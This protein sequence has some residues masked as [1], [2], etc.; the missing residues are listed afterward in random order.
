MTRK[1]TGLFG[2]LALFVLAVP[3]VAQTP[4]GGGPATGGGG[5]RPIPPADP[6]T[7]INRDWN[8][9]SVLGRRG[10]KLTGMVAVAGGSLP[11][12]PVLVTV[13]CD[14]KA[15][16]TTNTDP[17]GFF[18]I[19]AIDP[20]GSTTINANPKPVADQYVGC[21]VTAQVPG[22]DSTSL[23][24][25]TRHVTDS[26][27][28]GT[29]TLRREDGGS[30]FSSTTASAPKEATKA[31]EKARAE[32]LENKLDRAQGDLQKAVALD[33][34]FAEAW[35]QLGRIQ[36]SANS[37]EAKSSFAKAIAADPKFVL[38]YPH[39][40]TMAAATE[41]WQEAVS[42]TDQALA[43]D[44]RGGIDIFYYNALGNFQLKKL[45][46]AESSA[47]K[48]LAMD[49]LHRQPNTEQIL[50]LILY[51]KGD[52]AGALQHLRNCATYFPPGPNLDLVNQQIT[53]V[54]A[55]VKK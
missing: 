49:P 13:T 6:G 54:E 8:N 10:D 36:E 25:A 44:P 22:F 2:F 45:D 34:Q 31:F 4:K 46:A 53:T 42:Q 28:L 27:N 7:L 37:P 18:V 29:I 32:L 41:N 30:G 24:I 26:A 1:L 21:Q 19:A 5:S 9:L 3:G 35:Y 11:W 33:P 23:P 15:R 48:A 40:A 43:I 38:P 16:F 39:L 55:S 52:A 17:K 47:S 14:G 12:E 50:A 51:Q 20:I